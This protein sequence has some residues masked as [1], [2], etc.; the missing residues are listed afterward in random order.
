[1]QPPLIIGYSGHAFVVLAAL[2]SRKVLPIWYIDKEEKSVNPFALRYAGDEEGAW[3]KELLETHPYFVAIGNNHI[4]ERVV[5][6]VQGE[7]AE[8]IVHANAIV[9]PLAEIGAGVFIGPG[10]VVNPL[11]TLGQGAIVNSGAVVEHECRIGTFAHVAPGATLLGNVS[12]GARTLIGGNAVVL[13]GIN[14]GS[15]CTVGAGAVVR[16]N[17]PDGVT[18]VGNPAISI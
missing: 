3:A 13:P 10:A 1:M 14:I 17:V 9:D 2:T 18:V 15:D 16:H 4:R 11:A 6:S 12:V 7:L 5:T 8:A